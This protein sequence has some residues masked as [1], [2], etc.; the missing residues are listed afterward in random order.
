MSRKIKIA[1]SAVPHDYSESLVPLVIK[2]LGFEVEWAVPQKCDLLIIGPFGGGTR[3]TYR[4]LPR[5]LRGYFDLPIWGRRKR[6]L[7]FFHSA[8]CTRPD[9]IEADYSIGHDLCITSRK[10]FRLPYWME[11]LDWSHEGIWDNKNP[12]YGPLMK[13]EKLMSPMGGGCLKKPHKALFL[14]SHL[15]EPRKSI[16]DSVSKLI[17]VDCMGPYFDSQIK[18]HHHSAF[19]KWEIL[20]NYRFNLCP[21]NGIFP[22]YYTEKIPEAFYAES[23]PITWADMHVSNDFN[24]NALINL[25]EVAQL[26]YESL[27]E[28]LLDLNFLKKISQEPLLL[29]PPTL[30]P[31][32]AF[33]KNALQDAIT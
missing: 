2:S 16:L 3:K 1:L 14:T 21:E 18:S 31:L 33:V 29:K 19:K 28:Y 17:Q 13:I 6:P 22:G 24:P 12:R 27:G 32:K 4:W 9:L 5:G 15:R 11:M 10:H 8:E 30:E 23:I 20:Q 25:Y 26:G 7:I